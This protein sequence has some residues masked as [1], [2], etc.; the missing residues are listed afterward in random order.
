MINVSKLSII[1]LFFLLLIYIGVH[2][3][4]GKQL[5][6][7]KCKLLVKPGNIKLEKEFKKFGLWFKF[8]PIVYLVFVMF[9]LLS[10]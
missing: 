4:L 5:N 7:A 3:Y 1:P 9:I 10:M 8:F 6:K 2:Y